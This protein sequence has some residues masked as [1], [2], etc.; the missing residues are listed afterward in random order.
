[1]LLEL[2][3]LGAAGRELL[4]GLLAR[5]TRNERLLCAQLLGQLDDAA[6]VPA[7]GRACADEDALVATT[8]SRALAF[9]DAPAAAQALAALADRPNNQ[10]VQMNALFGLARGDVPG[11][12]ERAIA[13]LNDDKISS[14]AR[15]ALAG[16]L[17]MVNEPHL[18]PLVEQVRSRFRGHGVLQA[19]V[20]E[21]DAAAR[22]AP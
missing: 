1:V 6:A 15:V 21:Y 16:S 14:E 4:E 7:L 9:L 5:G 10:A 22:G 2:R 20:A 3:A 19:L 8:A 18:R 11:A 13:Y 12:V 17:A